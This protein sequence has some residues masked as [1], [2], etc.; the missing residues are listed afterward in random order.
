MIAYYESPQTN[1]PA[2]LLPALAKALSAST[3]A[4]LGL[5]P[6]PTRARA[7]GAG[8]R[9][10]RRLQQLEQLRPREKRQVLRLIDAFVER[11]KLKQRVGGADR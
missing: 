3:D 6:A 2:T 11:E 10:Q 9:L 4:L 5:T 8:S 1:P 7:A